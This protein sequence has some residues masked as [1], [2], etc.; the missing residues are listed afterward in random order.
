[1]YQLKIQI[2][3]ESNGLNSEK[4]NALIKAMDLILKI[5]RYNKR[6]RLSFDKVFATIKA[7]EIIW[8]NFTLQ[9]NQQ[10]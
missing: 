5:H 1:M 4:L 7:T 3:D 9:Y 8:K 10:T 2:S 6:N